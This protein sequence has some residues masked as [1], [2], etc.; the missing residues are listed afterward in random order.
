MEELF[1]ELGLGDMKRNLEIYACAE[2]FEEGGIEG[3]Y[4]N[5]L[6]EKKEARKLQKKD[7]GK[8]FK[9]SYF[10]TGYVCS[11]LEHVNYLL[12]WKDI[13]NSADSRKAIADELVRL[14][15]ELRNIK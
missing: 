14:A 8:E 3:L 4:K 5:T 11:K 7:M 12:H 10:E 9:E 1:K 6:K 13:I 2:A 15:E